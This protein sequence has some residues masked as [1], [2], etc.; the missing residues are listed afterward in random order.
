MHSSEQTAK[1]LARLG[2]QRLSR[3]DPKA[4]ADKLNEREATRGVRLTVY[5]LVRKALDDRGFNAAYNSNS[6]CDSALDAYA[7]A[8][9]HDRDDMPASLVNAGQYLQALTGQIPDMELCLKQLERMSYPYIIYVLFAG[10]GQS[11][12]VERLKPAF[13]EHMRRYPSTL[14]KL[15]ETYRKVAEEV[16]DA[17]V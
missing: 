17:D 13:L 14:D 3:I 9:E 11:S 10:S 15:P 4:L 8:A 12:L 2:S 16:H 5:G 1:E 7:T 6:V